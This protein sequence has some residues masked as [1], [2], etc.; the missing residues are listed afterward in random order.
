MALSNEGTFN[1]N[2]FDFE[3]FPMSSPTSVNVKNTWIVDSMKLPCQ[4]INID[5]LKAT[6]TTLQAFNLHSSIK[7]GK[8]Q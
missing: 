6:I 5:K 4:S 2:L 8:F 3:I 7:A 1:S